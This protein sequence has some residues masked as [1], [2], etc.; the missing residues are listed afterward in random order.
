M[1]GWGL[2]EDEVNP[3]V[4]MLASLPVVNDTQCMDA[5]RQQNLVITSNMFC[6]GYDDKRQSVCSG[7]SGSPFV[8][9]D[10]RKER[11]TLEGLVSFGVRGQCGV[12]GKYAIFTKVFRF[13]TWILR[14]SK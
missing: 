4:M 6:A 1:G 13:L 3:D 5:Y 2:T 10:K 7:D 9:Y 11:Y 12:A 14:N 8:F